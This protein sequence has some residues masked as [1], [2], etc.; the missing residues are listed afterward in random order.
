MRGLRQ[1]THSPHWGEKSVTTWSPGCDERDA[2]ADALDDARALVPQ[3]RRRV[4]GRVGARGGVEVGVADA[5]RDQPHEHLAGLRLRQVELLHLER[6]P[7]LLEHRG[8][9]LHCA[10]L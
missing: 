3:H 10:R 9:D 2:V 4:A 7:E 5:A 6:G 8:A 1:W